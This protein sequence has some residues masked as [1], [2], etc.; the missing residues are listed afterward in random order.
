MKKLDYLLQVEPVT[1]M[2]MLGPKGRDGRKN[3]VV[4]IMKDQKKGYSLFK[5]NKP[6]LKDAY[7]VLLEDV[8]KSVDRIAK[9][10][11]NKR[12]SK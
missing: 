3:L 12:K 7:V 2:L 4:V 1:A 11:L 8:D 5:K 6:I 10:L 9:A